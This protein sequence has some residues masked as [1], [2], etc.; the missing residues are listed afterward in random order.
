VDKPNKP[1]R[2]PAPP[3]AAVVEVNADTER[4]DSLS[5]LD[6]NDRALMNRVLVTAQKALKDSEAR[7]RE[8]SEAIAKETA[9]RTALEGK[10]VSRFSDYDAQLSELKE[11]VGELRGISGDIRGLRGDLGALNADVRANLAA[12]AGR[13]RS[14]YE[15]KLQVEKMA[16]ESGREAGGVAGAKTARW[17]GLLSGTSGPIVFAFLIW[18]I[19]T[20]VNAL[21]GKPPP[22]MPTLTPAPAAS[23]APAPVPSAGP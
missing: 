14:H 12:D 23:S 18:L 20:F 17:W 16:T 1:D 7:A 5:A 13:E 9:E 6:D 3:R 15:L 22:P 4:H 2:L 19:T 21:S 10:M 11:T 8:A